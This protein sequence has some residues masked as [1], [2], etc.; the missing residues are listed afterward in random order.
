MPAARRKLAQQRHQLLST[1]VLMG[2]NR[3]VVTSGRIYARM[4][5][6]I[7]ATDTAKAES[8]SQFDASHELD[9]GRPA[10]SLR[11]S[12]SRRPRSP[13]SPRRRRTRSDAINVQADL[14]GEVDLKF[15]SETFPLERFADMGAIQQ[16]QGNTANP[17]ANTPQSQS[18][19]SPATAPATAGS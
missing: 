19:A 9:R 3:I 13:T 16:I 15:K 14:T 5:F 4:G 17:A 11:R 8:A 12:S 18:N 10:S 2:I 7:D 1:M 6:Y